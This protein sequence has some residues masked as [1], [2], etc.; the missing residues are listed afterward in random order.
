MVSRVAWSF[1]SLLVAASVG[2]NAYIAHAAA[3]RTD[4]NKR[5]P[6]QNAAMIQMLNG[7]GL[8]MV[9]LRI[10]NKSS[11]VALVPVGLLMAGTVMFSGC[12]FYEKLTE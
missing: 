11:K 1:G 3:F 6:V 5:L 10:G 4:A 7:L 12:I 8:M 9:S 2:E